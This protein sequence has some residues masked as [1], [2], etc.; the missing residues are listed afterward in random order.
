MFHLCYLCYVVM[1]MSIAIFIQSFIF[2]AVELV[3]Q[4][5]QFGSAYLTK[6]VTE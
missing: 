2:N 6:K 1:K 3:T 4:T 5:F